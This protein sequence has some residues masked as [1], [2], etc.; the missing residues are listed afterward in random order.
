MSAAAS[1]QANRSEDNDS[2]SSEPPEELNFNSN[3]GNELADEDLPMPTICVYGSNGMAGPL[4]LDIRQNNELPDDSCCECNVTTFNGIFMLLLRMRI[5][6]QMFNVQS[7]TDLKSFYSL[8][9]L[10][11]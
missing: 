4:D 3:N 7:K 5:R 9:C 2:D 11:W 6:M 8:C 1:N 10:T